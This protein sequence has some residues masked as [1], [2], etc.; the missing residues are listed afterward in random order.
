MAATTLAMDPAQARG[1][2]VCI[3]NLNH[4]HSL[5]TIETMI[6]SGHFMKVRGLNDCW[7]QE[8]KIEVHRW[9]REGRGD[10]DVVVKRVPT[11]HVNA[12]VDKDGNERSLHACLTDR[13][14]EDTLSEIG[15]YC[16]LRQQH[17]P[18]QYILKMHEVFRAGSETWL[19]LENAEGG[20]LFNMLSNLQ[21]PPGA[22]Q[23]ATWMWQLLQA[24]D[25]LHRHNIGHR[26]ISLEN[27]LVRGGNLRLM[28]FGMAVQARSL[29]GAPLRYF[30]STGKP[31]YRAPEC[32]VP[33]QR[34]VQVVVPTGSHPGETVFA[35]TTGRFICD[36][37]LP[38]GAVPGQRCNAE[39]RGYAVEPVDIFACGVTL[40][41]LATGVPPWRAACLSDTL[42]RWVHARNA[43][44]LV[45]SWGYSLPPDAGNLLSAMM[46]SDPTGRPSIT[47]CL[48][49]PWFAPF[50]DQ[51]V[52]VHEQENVTAATA[53]E[54]AALN[55][56]D[57][58]GSAGEGRT[59]DK[60]QEITSS[61]TEMSKVI[62]EHEACKCEHVGRNKTCKSE[63][64]LRASRSCLRSA[65]FPRFKRFSG[66]CLRFLQLVTVA[67]HRPHR[68]AR[69]VSR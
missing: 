25:Y 4:F 67:A 38:E 61:L 10:E 5:A 55:E 48:A 23:V 52:P 7:H 3:T 59:D 41:I 54:A 68:L 33:T 69:N 31:Y 63:L 2:D 17:D 6:S 11:E 24:V 39:P 66:R 21:V 28:D 46:R 58:I 60:G 45:A 35:Q 1:E 32:Y 42:F 49:H 53:C 50:H 9:S 19:V 43:A 51:L 18:P 29:S 56:E 40:F 36:V 20:D 57:V 13:R 65:S 64:R 8:G 37:L 15:I 22:Q 16:F 47:S 34:L 12:N 44:D 62:L 27:V 30:S 14:G 26:D